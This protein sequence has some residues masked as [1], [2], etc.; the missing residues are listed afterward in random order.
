VV[1]KPTWQ[2][3]EPVDLERLISVGVIRRPHGVRGEASVELLTDD[4]E[5]FS[6][7]DRVF[8]V[9]P[10]RSRSVVSRIEAA[11]SHHDRALVK[12]QAIDSPE[13]LAEYRD[14]SIELPEDEAR[15]LD[16]G[17]YFLHDLMGMD[18]VDVSGRSIGRVT[19]ILQGF[20][21]TLLRIRKPR[22]GSFDMPFA[23][24]YCIEIDIP[25]K[26]LVVELPGGLEDLGDDRGG[27]NHDDEVG[28]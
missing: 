6:S 9:A 21:Q 4:P 2:N 8:L 1:S 10:D 16:D 11:R 3:G 15:K 18:V 12:L 7:L 27:P 28:E 14:W 22:G 13:A 5:R 17:E 25:G 26:R 23:S 20:G 19:E 24:A